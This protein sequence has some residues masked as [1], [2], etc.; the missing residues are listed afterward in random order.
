MVG[1]DGKPVFPTQIAKTV[2]LVRLV[3]EVDLAEDH[4]ATLEISAQCSAV[5]APFG[6]E[7]QDRI[8]GDHLSPAP[9]EPSFLILSKT[10]DEF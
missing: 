7:D 2:H 4:P 8:E 10:I 5:G 1:H 3:A 6:G 9:P